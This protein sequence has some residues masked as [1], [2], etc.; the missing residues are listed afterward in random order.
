VVIN[1]WGAKPCQ[2]LACAWPRPTDSSSE[3]SAQYVAWLKYVGLLWNKE[4]QVFL[5]FRALK[6]FF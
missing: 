4:A 5:E 3:E 2:V 1:H 6:I